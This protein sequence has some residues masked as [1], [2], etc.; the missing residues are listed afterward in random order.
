ME[1]L[2]RHWLGLA[3]LVTFALAASSM[4]PDPRHANLRTF[5]LFDVFLLVW[6]FRGFVR[7]VGRAWHHSI[8]Q[9]PK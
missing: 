2:Q 7:F 9:G 3:V 8:T 6:M 4:I 5:G 1:F